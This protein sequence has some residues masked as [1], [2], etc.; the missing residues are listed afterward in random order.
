MNVVVKKAEIRSGLFLS[1]EYDQKDTDVNNTIKTQSDAPIHDDLRDA[2]RALTPHFVFVCEEIK[3]EALVQAAIDTPED[4]FGFRDEI[5]HEDFISY[6]VF[7]F[8]LSKNEEG[9]V[10]SGAKQLAIGSEI[11]FTTPR[12]KFDSD[13]KF[14]SALL[15][16]VEVLKSEVLEYMSG[17]QAEKSQL[18]LFGGE[19]EDE[20]FGEE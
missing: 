17:K 15:Q 10:I 6:R 9:I 7:G 12:V 13:Y 1:Y 14:S 16:S 19:E 20:A 3:D 8:T 11:A 5:K 4:Y 2:F 18:A